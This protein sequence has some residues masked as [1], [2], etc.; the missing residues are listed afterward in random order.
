MFHSVTAPTVEPTFVET[1]TAYSTLAAA[2]ATTASVVF[3]AWQIGLTRKSVQATEKTLEVAREE[4]EN[5]R[6]LEVEAQRARI[7][8]EMPRLFVGV[9]YESTQA[10]L[11]DSLIDDGLSREPQAEEITAEKEFS[12]PRDA[13]VRVQ[14]SLGLTVTNDGPRRAMV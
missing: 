12:L 13:G 1:L 2:V 5:G 9:T 11:P 3:I 8:A 4:F 14:V 10:W 7:D 6:L